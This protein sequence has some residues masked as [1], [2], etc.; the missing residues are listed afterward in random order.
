MI[1][2]K[3]IDKYLIFILKNLVYWLTWTDRYALYFNDGTYYLTGI[4]S[5]KLSSGCLNV[6]KW[7]FIFML[8]NFILYNGKEKYADVG[9]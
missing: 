7:L 6:Y 5:N 1:L 2:V 9:E 3:S 8:N 4:P